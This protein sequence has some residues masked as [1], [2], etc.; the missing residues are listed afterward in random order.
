MNRLQQH[1][2]KYLL[3]ACFYFG[4]AVVITYPLITVMSTHLFG[5]FLTDSYQTAR[6]V[7]WIKHALQN[8]ESL[9]Q[10]TTLGYPDGLE[11]AW[12]WANPLEYFPGWLFAF[13]MPINTA[14][15]LMLLLQ[16]TLNG[17]S[18]FILI[19][20]LTDKRTYPALLGGM[21]FMAFPA[22]QGRI[23]GGHVGVLALWGVPL[24]IYAL[25]RLRAEF[26]WRW[27]V[28]AGVCTLLGIAGNSTLLVYYLLPTVGS[29]LVLQIVTKQWA[30]LQRS[31]MAMC[32]GGLLSLILLIPLLIETI[33]TPQYTLEMSETV[34][35]SA[36]LL[37]FAS[38]SIDGH[39]LF[40]SLDYPTRV[41]GLNL[42]EGIGYIGIIV[43]LLAILGAWKHRQARWWVL[44]ALI[45]WVFSL[46]ALLKVEDTP[47]TIGVDT[48]ESHIS[49]PWAG[50]QNL[51]ILN[52]SRTA[53]R[54]N[55][56]VALAMSVMASYGAV[57]LWGKVAHRRWRG[58]MLTLLG[59]A[60]LFEFQMFWG[61]PTDEVIVSDG[62]HDLAER[63]DIRAVFNIP[64]NDRIFAKHGLYLQTVHQ[65]NIIAG[66]F[67][68][69][70]PVNPARL[71]VLQETLDPA[72][73]D[74]AGVDVVIFHRLS[75]EFSAPFE[76]FATA[77]LGSPIHQDPRMRIFNVPDMDAPPEF[78]VVYPTTQAITRGYDLHF[79]APQS[80]WAR[81]AMTLRSDDLTERDLRL[82][83]DNTQVQALTVTDGQSVDL[84]IPIA[85]A[86]F[87]T[88]SL[89][90]DPLCPQVTNAVLRCN[91]VQIDDLSFDSF[92]AQALDS[93]IALS[94]GVT[95]TGGFVG[96]VN[97][98]EILPLGLWWDFDDGMSDF[99]SRFVHVVHE[100][101]EIVAQAD[102][103]LFAD[104]D[105][106]LVDSPSVTLPDDAPAGRYRVY[107]GFYTYPDI[108]RFTVHS[109][110]EGAV[111]G[112][113]LV[114]EF[115]VE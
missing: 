114:G 37:A 60:I 74:Y 65:Q 38:P 12:L 9:F 43:G 18:A 61:M 33:T 59:V 86:G 22:L 25:Y 99:A 20:Y 46:G 88:V 94:Y 104:V 2:L 89:Q 56:T 108:T 8:G 44:V 57:Y 69:D 14:T 3:L 19:D 91:G 103:P 50:L 105:S 79:F 58:A 73:L 28:L 41:L 7:W 29:L 63:D 16:L 111:N 6:H 10:Q 102:H 112:L 85:E 100:D 67:I 31:L 47:V 55:L 71:V 13:V 64:W 48:Y 83:L 1:H 95:L 92:T 21:I 109:E 15:N 4:V 17:V 75:P 52:I 78:T 35:F 5:D 34:R 42:V 97:G 110:E 76:T 113:V 77:Q 80:G 106:T 23:Y 84:W 81:L 11:G 45:A 107:T 98:G 51:P 26:H 101:G 82:L 40:E 66:Q 115:V 27:V 62:I 70:T 49:L 87:H 39:P 72:I 96:A 32:L 53:G 30:W 24:V 68:R 36:D 90:L 93:P 54:F